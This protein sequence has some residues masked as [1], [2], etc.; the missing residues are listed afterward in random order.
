[1]LSNHHAEKLI[2]SGD[3]KGFFKDSLSEVVHN[4]SIEAKD[5]TLAYL[6]NLL[7]AFTR[8]DAGFHRNFDGATLKPLALL[9]AEAVEAASDEE[10][11][12]ALR[13]LGDL[14]LFVAGVFADCL[15]RKLVDVDYFI[16]MGG[17]AYS[18]LSD[19]MPDSVRGRTY[20]EIFEE[21][22][23]KFSEFVDVLNEFT[24][25]TKLTSNVDIMRLYELWLRTGSKHAARKL[26][27]VGIHVMEGSISRLHH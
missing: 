9:Y 2:A 21:L 16:A 14:S 1:M 5:D 26:R 17:N 22:S 23:L 12:Q 19:T 3:V 7:V 10:R 24:D 11:R 6:V 4:R 27:R 20:S 13:Q 8:V 18:Y 15:N 25:K